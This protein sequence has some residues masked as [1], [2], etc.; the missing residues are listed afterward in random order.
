MELVE[1]A[2]VEANAAKNLVRITGNPKNEKVAVVNGSLQDSGRD[3]VNRAFC[4]RLPEYR[5]I[6]VGG[7]AVNAADVVAS[8]ESVLAKYFDLD[9]LK[10]GLDGKGPVIVILDDGKARLDVLHAMQAKYPEL[11]YL[12][13]PG[14]EIDEL[15]GELVSAELVEPELEDENEGARFRNRIRT[16]A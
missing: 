13:L 15:R 6:R 10:E 16:L 7:R 3:Y 5:V 9:S 8:F 11:T 12:L 2:W 14:E 1:P 4:C